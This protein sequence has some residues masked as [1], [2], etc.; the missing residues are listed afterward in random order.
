MTTTT[1][2]RA[3]APG[4]TMTTT[5]LEPCRVCDGVNAPHFDSQSRLEDGTILQVCGLCVASISSLLGFTPDTAVEELRN[6][7]LAA[8]DRVKDAD[9]KTQAARDEA[10]RL[11]AELDR[12][13]AALETSE[14]RAQGF[15][16]AFNEARKELKDLAELK[17]EGL[18]VQRYASVF[19]EAQVSK[20]KTTRNGKAQ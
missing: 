12:A 13:E 2:Q 4:F 15:Q 5:E 1:Y 3:A 6:E 14:Q 11:V 16:T 18:T 7:I 8:N 20:T 9:D 17:G 19:A 10:E